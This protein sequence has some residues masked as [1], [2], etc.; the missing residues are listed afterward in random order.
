[1]N[2]GLSILDSSQAVHYTLSTGG[3]GGTNGINE[4]NL[5][6]PPGKLVL[7]ATSVVV[8]GGKAGVAIHALDPGNPRR[9]VDGQVYFTTYDFSPAVSDFHLAPDDLVSVQLYQQNPIAGYPTWVNGIG[10][11]LRQ[12][13][14]L[15]PIMGRFQLWTYQGVWE[16]RDKIQRVLSLDI[17]QPLHMPATRD[18]SAIRC[19]LVLD[20]FSAGMPYEQLGLAGGPGT[21]WNN[22][23]GVSNWGRLTGLV[24][25]SG[26]IV[27]S[28]APVYGSQAAPPEGGSGG[29]SSQVDFTGDSLVAISGVTGTY[30]GAVQVAQ[31]TFRT[32]AGKNFGPFGSLRNVSSNQP[33]DLRAPAGFRISSFFGTTFTHTGGTAFIASIGGNV[34]PI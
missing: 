20:W 23:P 30:F 32:A 26:D 12:F 22:L 7:S 9:Y 29:T 8:Q 25:R 19:K 10:N 6:T 17:S 14:M 33:F 4:S 5:S 13:G 27:D 18:L 21:S 24:V 15:Y 34:V 11:I 16:N 1:V 28:I 3:T 2:I 31:L